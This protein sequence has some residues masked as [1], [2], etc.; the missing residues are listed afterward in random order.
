[1]RALKIFKISMVLLLVAIFMSG[2]ASTR[3]A[4]SQ[5]ECA[6]AGAT[7]GG[8]FGALIGGNQGKT[9]TNYGNG[10]VVRD[11]DTLN[12]VAGTLIGVTT[13]AVIGKVACAPEPQPVQYAPVA[14][15]TQRCPSG[16]M[17]VRDVQTGQIFCD[18]PVRQ[19]DGTY[20][21]Y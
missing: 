5:D 11:R 14:Q 6:V 2:C 1:M 13:G 15:Y 7:L 18:R 12:T 16:Q 8:A 21:V 19:S 10:V 4:L 9:N 20:R 17:L 3:S